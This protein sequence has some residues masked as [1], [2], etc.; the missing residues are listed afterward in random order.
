MTDPLEPLKAITQQQQDEFGVRRE[1]MSVVQTKCVKCDAW[2]ETLKM[3]N[4]YQEAFLCDCGNP[5][6]FTVSAITIGPATIKEIDLDEKFESGMRIKDAIASACYWWN[7]TGRHSM[8]KDGGKGHAV[9]ISLDPS[10]DNYVPSGILN[11]E[12]WDVL[13]N[14][15]R[16][17][18]T[19][20]WHHHFI[21][22]P[23]QES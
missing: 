21:S 18:I 7:K 4:A 1:T 2:Y 22:K 13:D 15:E 10:S 9:A 20:A 17:Q 6:S 3:N 16:L 23:Q 11:G 8:R 14:R 12:P 19:K 5:I